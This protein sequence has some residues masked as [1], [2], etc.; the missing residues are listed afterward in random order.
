ML[1]RFIIL[2]HHDI[3]SQDN[4]PDL[5]YEAQVVPASW[6]FSMCYAITSRV[7]DSSS[8]WV[9][10][11]FIVESSS[12]YFM[13]FYSSINSVTCHIIIRAMSCHVISFHFISNYITKS[14]KRFVCPY[15]YPYLSLLTFLSHSL[16]YLSYLFLHLFHFM[17]YFLQ[18]GKFIMVKNDD[19]APTMTSLFSTQVRTWN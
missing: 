6:F 12:N 4:Y 5:L 16:L 10:W 1:I 3:L 8:R 14:T 15:P 2:L 19:V 13:F 7:M 17:T 18:S 9:S 11:I